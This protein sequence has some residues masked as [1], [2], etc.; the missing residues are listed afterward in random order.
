[1]NGMSINRLIGVMFL[2]FIIEG[3]IMPWIIPVDLAGRIVPH[4]T[5]VF[6]IY[7]ALYSGRHHALLLGIGFGMLQDVVFFGHLMGVHAFVMGLIGYFTG[8]LLERKRSTLLTA[9]SVIGLACLVNDT[10]VYFIY[11]AFRITNESYAWALLDHILPSLFLQL[12]FALI[13]Y[14]P[15]RKLCES[16]WSRGSEKEEE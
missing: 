10:F 16:S 8:L 4:F 3:A 15:A 7:A 1:M 9:L 13:C 14:V 12:V 2:L 5:F 6:V 11:K